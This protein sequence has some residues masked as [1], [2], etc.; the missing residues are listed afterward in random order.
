MYNVTDTKDLKIFLSCL[1]E[2]NLNFDNRIKYPLICTNQPYLL[3]FS[4]DKKYRIEI[5][6]NFYYDGATIFRC[7][8][9]V[10]GHPLQPEYQTASIFHD[11]ICEHKEVI[12]N[13]RKLSSEIFYNL[14]L[15]CKVNKLLAKIMYLAVD[16]FQKTQRW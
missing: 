9:R 8:W 11:Y 15:F 14:L 13:N 7:F 16:N 1:P 5:P 10:A 12:E 4:K 3:V 2:V 6:D